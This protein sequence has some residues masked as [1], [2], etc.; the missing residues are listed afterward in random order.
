MCDVFKESC[1]WSTGGGAQGEENRDHQMGRSGLQWKRLHLQP[2]VLAENVANRNLSIGSPTGQS[3]RP[4]RPDNEMCSQR[5]QRSSS[6]SSD[7]EV[8][9][10]S[11]PENLRRT[12]PNSC[13]VFWCDC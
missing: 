13:C 8:T 10:S 12:I 9:G 4:M 1:Q 6:P 2:V 3:I 7:W 11:M 5:G